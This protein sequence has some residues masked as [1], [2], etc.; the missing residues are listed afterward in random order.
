MNLIVDC[1][2]II[3]SSVLPEENQLQIQYHLY[4][5][6]APAIFYLECNNVLFSALK[7]KRISSVDYQE[8]LEAVSDLPINIDKFSCA[9]ESLHFISELAI[10]NNLSSY[11]ASYLE[12]AIRLKAKIA[13]FDKQLIEACKMNSI[14]VLN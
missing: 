5:I 3:M 14:E 7:R 6:Y 11:D 1:S 10:K 13:T 2:V 12:L 9:P 8:Y 4:K